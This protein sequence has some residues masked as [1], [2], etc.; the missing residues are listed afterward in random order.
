MTIRNCRADMDTMTK[1]HNDEIRRLNLKLN[2][3]DSLIHKLKDEIALLRS[4]EAGHNMQPFSQEISLNTEIAS[5]RIQL[6]NQKYEM[7]KL[8]EERSNILREHRALAP[9][10]EEVEQMR[11]EKVTMTKKLEALRAD[12]RNGCG[13]QDEISELKK[14]VRAKHR[15]LVKVRPLLTFNHIPVLHIRAILAKFVFCVIFL[16]VYSFEQWSGPVLVQGMVG[17]T[18]VLERIRRESHGF[19]LLVA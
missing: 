12:A 5:M 16:V 1:K 18:V 6:D 14:D 11:K 8:K 9:I 17:R 3:R 13:H 7:R 2:E 15:E 4:M 19:L 10:N